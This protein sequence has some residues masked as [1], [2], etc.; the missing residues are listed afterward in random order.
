MLSA[1]SKIGSSILRLAGAIATNHEGDIVR[2]TDLQ[3][4]WAQL[5]QRAAAKNVIGRHRPGAA[6]WPMQPSRATARFAEAATKDTKV[7]H[8][9]F[10]P[11]LREPNPATV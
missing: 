5:V 7:S 11:I 3:D 4:Y 6:R 9:R 2:A 8:P 10:S 1:G